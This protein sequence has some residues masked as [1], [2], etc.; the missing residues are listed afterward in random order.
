MKDHFASFAAR[1][2][3]ALLT[4][5]LLMM[6]HGTVQHGVLTAVVP[7]SDTPWELSK[8][9]FWPLAICAAGRLRHGFRAVSRDLPALVL[10][11]PAAALLCRG[12]Q[13]LGGDGRSFLAVWAAVLAAALAY[14]PDGGR[15][16]YVWSALAVILA[17]AYVL[18]TLQPLLWQPLLLPGIASA[19]LFL[20]D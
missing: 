6:L 3:T 17:G 18:L 1:Y 9:V 4:G 5:L 14:G 19:V 2:L 7:Q 13:M 11:P 15:L 12:I 8:I 20:A 10:A 16:F